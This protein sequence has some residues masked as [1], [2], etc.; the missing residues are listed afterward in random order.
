MFRCAN[1]TGG[2][3]DGLKGV[4]DT[5]LRWKTRLGTVAFAFHFSRD[6]DTRTGVILATAQSDSVREENVLP[7][8]VD[9]ARDRIEKQTHTDAVAGLQ[10]D[11]RR[12]LVDLATPEHPG[13]R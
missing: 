12:A 8:A 9:I 5:F 10:K 3:S 13:K 2:G 1:M 11:I 6:G 7:G 4:C